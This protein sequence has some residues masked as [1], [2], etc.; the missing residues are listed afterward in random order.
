[1]T[2]D[3]DT[4]RP[5]SHSPGPGNPTGGAPGSTRHRGSGP[6]CP[7]PAPSSSS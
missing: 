6:W 3:I 7:R 5:G 1:M 2:L 4:D